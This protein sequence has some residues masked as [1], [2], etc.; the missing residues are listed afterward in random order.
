MRVRRYL[1]TRPMWFRLSTTTCG[2]LASNQGDSKKRSTSQGLGALFGDCTRI[3]PSA[4][5]SS[6]TKLYWQQMLQE[7]C[8][9][10]WSAHLVGVLIRMP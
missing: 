6:L 1:S 5:S 9:S 8:Q 3:G 2:G 4:T 10:R 7:R